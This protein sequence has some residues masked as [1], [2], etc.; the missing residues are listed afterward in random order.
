[1]LPQHM[2]VVQ[3]PTL[4]VDIGFDPAFVPNTGATPNLGEK[5]VHALVDTGAGESFIDNDLAARLKLP[6]IDKQTISGSAGRHEVPMYLAQI[7]V[8]SIDITINGRFGG[9]NLAA[10]GQR[11][12]ALIGRSFLMHFK[13]HYDGLTGV[14]ELTM[15]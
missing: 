15:P 5:A 2:L 6:V 11:H 7:H 3:G 10:G 4:V 12:S 13:M 1:M 9:V 8:P 14:V